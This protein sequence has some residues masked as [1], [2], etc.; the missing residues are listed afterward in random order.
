MRSV[1]SEQFVPIFKSPYRNMKAALDFHRYVFFALFDVN[2]SLSA[3]V[4]LRGTFV[5]ATGFGSM[6]F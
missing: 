3:A 4:V 6:V 1:Q 2:I 5:L